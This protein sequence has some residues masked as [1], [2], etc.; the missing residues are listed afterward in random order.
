ME[1]KNKPGIY[2]HIPFCVRKCNYC[3][4]LSA[5]GTDEVIREYVKALKTEIRERGGALNGYEASSLYFGGG[6]PSAIDPG[7]IAEIAGKIKDIFRFE[8]AAECTIEVNPGTVTYEKLKCYK[9]AGFNRLSVGIQS[10]DDSELKLLGRIHRFPDAVKTF[11]DAR[12]AGFTNISADVISALPGQSLERYESNLNRIIELA[13]EHISSYSLIIEEGTPFYEL[14]G[15]SGKEKGMLPDEETDRLMYKRTSEI[16]EEYGYHRY[17]ISNYARAGFESRHNSSYWTGR[18][19]IGF[20]LGAA[21]LLNGVRSSGERDLCKYMEDPG[22]QTVDEVLDDI[23]KQKE[24]MML[25]L[26]MTR[27]ISKREFS[28]RFGIAVR[29]V[30]G[31]QIDKLISEGLITED[32]EMIKLTE[33]GLDVANV[34]FGE[35][36]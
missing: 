9:D 20:G 6:T 3:D 10:A 24:F 16:L 15:P 34:V 30:F 25:G 31:A 35:F 17:E 12:K 22:K 27:G 26:R 21:S 1:R 19:Y 23:A 18:D 8:K 4:F 36:V 2:V 5:P 28:E 11:D 33:F 32:D 13:P 14:Y 7:L 29:E